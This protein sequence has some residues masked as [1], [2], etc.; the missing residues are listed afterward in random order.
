M[1][2]LLSFASVLIALQMIISIFCVAVPADNGVLLMQNTKT[3][4]PTKAFLYTDI[5]TRI[6]D[7]NDTA[8]TSEAELD[9]FKCIEVSVN[10]NTSKPD[11]VLSLDNYE[12]QDVSGNIDLDVY[13]YITLIYKYNEFVPEG[14]PVPGIYIATHE[15]TIVGGAFLTPVITRQFAQGWKTT[16]LEI[17]DLSEKYSD[18]DAAHYLR[19]FHIMPYGLNKKTPTVSSIPEGAKVYVQGIIFHKDMPEQVSV[20]I[21]YICGNGDGTFRPSKVMT[22]AEACSVI[23]QIHGISHTSEFDGISSFT[24]VK[25]N[26][27]Y[28]PYVSYCESL[29]LLKS[30]TNTFEPETPVTARELSLFITGILSKDALSENNGLNESLTKHLQSKT[31]TRAD[32]VALINSCLGRACDFVP[33]DVDSSLSDVD[34]GLWAKND[35]ISSS[36]AHVI[37]TEKGQSAWLFY[38]AIAETL[39]ESIYLA[40]EKKLAEVNEKSETRIYEI[41]NTETTVTV[42]GKSYYFSQYGDDSNDG[43]SPSTPKKSLKALSSL[44]LIY[45]D[46]VFFNRGETFRGTV[47]AVEGVTYSAYGYGEKPV[48]TA[49][50]CDFAGEENWVETEVENVWKLT[51]PISKD[52]GLVVFDGGKQ[53]SEKR[54]KGRNDFKEG[55]LTE[56]D[57]DLL[58]W[59]D[60]PSPDMTG[61]LYLR[62]DTGNPGIRFNS[63]ELSPRNHILVA[64]DNILVDNICFKYTGAHGISS[65]N[66]KNLTVQNCEFQFIGGSWFRTD[67]L[68]RYGNAVE[69]Y[70][71]C[72][73][74]T[75]NN[76]YINQVYDAGVT[77]QLTKSPERE[78]IMKDIKYTNNVITNT[79]YP[80]EYF[81]NESNEGVTHL[82]K[83]VEISGNIIL[84]TGFGFG[85]QR[86]DKTAAADI[87]G[88]SAY[89]RS[90]GF[91]IN[92]NVFGPSK[93]KIMHVG[94]YDA[95][96]LPKY[97]GNT[98][99][100]YHKSKFGNIGDTSGK[101]MLGIASDIKEKVGDEKAEVYFLR[102]IAE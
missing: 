92:K 96:W 70:G 84:G 95:A 54:I 41:R 19:H 89:N 86:P 6:V 78:C 59:H 82:M 36:I 67:T 32:A 2:K 83:N 5:F 13:K 27:W 4:Y 80:V 11:I 68:S 16:V 53:W 52:V 31:L 75:V 7:G 98:F 22:R 93:Y 42:T 102:P 61:Y 21:P 101:Y 20:D 40:G 97:S 72:D 29:G 71:S 15:Q 14:N 85:D 47:T 46:G 25:E 23:A 65:G 3:D 56:L 63:I 73:G 74:Y 49:S 81:I 34:K 8:T 76:C 91:V 48:L 99:I 12:F 33:D 45:G 37:L 43:L 35:I 87:K 100:Q 44:P 60:I 88:W 18:P 58:I 24:D 17:P 77:H 39:D 55:L 66:V 50:P 38:P 57:K 51:T 28:Y 79:S 90:E 64:K 94:A 10:K 30:Y 1:K 26:A 9:G 69:V 62:S